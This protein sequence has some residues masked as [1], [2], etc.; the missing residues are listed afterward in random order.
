MRNTCLF[1]GD[2]KYWLMTHWLGGTPKTTHSA[3]RS[4][5]PKAW[6]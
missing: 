5:R 6:S 2:H 4:T 1:L 3:S